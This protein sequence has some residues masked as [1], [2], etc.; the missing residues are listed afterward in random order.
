MKTLEA[1]I[2]EV[3]E[4]ALECGYDEAVT[5]VGDNFSDK[6]CDTKLALWDY[7]AEYCESM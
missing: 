6:V 7:F 5:I 1:L 2:A 4:L 3:N